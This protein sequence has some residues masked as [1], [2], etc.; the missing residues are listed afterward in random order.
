MKLGRVI[1]K[2]LLE[3]KRGEVNKASYSICVFNYVYRAIRRSA[4]T[5]RKE[6]EDAGHQIDD[7]LY[8][9]LVTLSR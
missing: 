6:V 5:Q 7:K 3:W 2:T 1:E 9:K 8:E 4:T